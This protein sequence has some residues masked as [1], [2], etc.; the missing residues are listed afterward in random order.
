MRYLDQYSDD[1]LAVVSFA[2]HAALAEFVF[3]ASV[4]EANFDYRVVS[5]YSI[6]V[7]QDEADWCRQRAD[8]MLLPLSDSSTG[9]PTKDESRSS[10]EKFDAFIDQLAQEHDTG[11]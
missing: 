9:E 11:Q 2:T 10:R 1:A 6:V 8:E 4:E 5:A 3:T 7:P